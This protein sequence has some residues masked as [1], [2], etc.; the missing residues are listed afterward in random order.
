MNDKKDLNNLGK[1][2]HKMQQVVSSSCGALVTALLMT[3]LDVIKIRLQ[4]QNHMKHKGDCFFYRNGLMDH[5]CTCFNGPESWYN[6][7]IPGGRYHGTFDA[8]VKIAKVE[9]ITSLWSGL[10]PTLFM[11]FP[12]VVLY[13]TTYEEMKRIMGYHEIH[14]SNSFIPILSGGLA[15]MFAVTAVSPIE[16]I[17]TKIQSEKLKY[18]DM[19][20]AVKFAIKDQGLKSLY[21][22]WVS[23]VLRDVPFSMIYWFNYESLKSFLLKKQNNQNLSSKSVFFCGASAGSIAA[24][25]T[26]PLDVVK[27]YRQIQLGEK[28]AHKHARKTWNIIRQIYKT[29]G[30]S[31]LFAGATPRVAKVAMSCAI[32][33]TTFEYF[34][35]LFE[36]S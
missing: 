3:P 5:L 29:K 19:V 8:M 10:P 15:R 31:G 35:N 20:D 24:L 36:H 9:G 34:K 21:R 16:L 2:S 33:I 22:G 28:D 30:V 32:M 13:F 18:T 25:I 7:K 27:T 6:R 11:A 17:R 14:N 1:K 12:Q 23:T 26:C 4:S